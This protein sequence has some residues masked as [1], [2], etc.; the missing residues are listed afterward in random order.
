[1]HDQQR[2]KVHKRPPCWCGRRNSVFNFPHRLMGAPTRR[3]LTHLTWCRLALGAVPARP[4]AHNGG[5][6]CR[7]TAC[8]IS[9]ERCC[10]C[11]PSPAH[12]SGSQRG[13]KHSADDAAAVT[14]W[15][16][17]VQT[18]VSSEDS[19][20]RGLRYCLSLGCRHAHC[21]VPR[22]GPMMA[23]RLRRTFACAEGA[24]RAAVSNRQIAHD[25][26]VGCSARCSCA[27]VAAAG[28]LLPASF[29]PPGAGPAVTTSSDVLPRGCA[30]SNNDNCCCARGGGS[31]GLIPVPSV[32]AAGLSVA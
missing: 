7:A 24:R 15:G 27:D 2:P 14:V 17:T 21:L 25:D 29:Q 5:F 11:C 31:R 16:A 9:H 13:A 8:E 4:R 10:C 28:P 6:G 19:E 30:V 3:H 1:M 26:C 32:K 18:A 12:G 22:T 20:Q 23:P